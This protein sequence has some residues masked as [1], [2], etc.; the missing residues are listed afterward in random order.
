MEA[1][2]VG[3]VPTALTK[4]HKAFAEGRIFALAIIDAVMP[5]IDGFT[6]AGWIKHDPRLVGGDDLDGFRQP[7]ADAGLPLPRNSTLLP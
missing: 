3:D 2:A 6:L 1:V 4:I 5:Q 7:V